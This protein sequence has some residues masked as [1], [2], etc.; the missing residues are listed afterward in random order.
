MR[1]ILGFPSFLA[2]LWVSL[3]IVVRRLFF[4][5]GNMYSFLR[6]S[7]LS[8]SISFVDIGLMRFLLCFSVLFMVSVFRC[9]SRSVHLICTSSP[10]LHPV[11]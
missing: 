8:I 4:F 9:V 1:A 11:S 7:W 3:S 6:G 10:N 2:V 5:I